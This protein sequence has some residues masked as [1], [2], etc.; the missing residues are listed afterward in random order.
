MEKLDKKS[1]PGTYTIV[2]NTVFFSFTYIKFLYFSGFRSIPGRENISA[3]IK[4][5]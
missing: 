4:Q 5:I 1:F 3:D 2:G